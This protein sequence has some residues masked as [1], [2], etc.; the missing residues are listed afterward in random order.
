MAT[1]RREVRK[2]GFFGWFFLIIFLGFNAAML[3]LVVIYWAGIGERLSDAD[4]AVQAG[5]AMGGTV[6]TFILFV[7]WALGA[8]ITGLL[9]LVT[10]GRTTVVREYD[11]R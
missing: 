5:T 11:E 4:P 8:G 3:A 2:R 9:A 6:G 1:V 10:R 7:F